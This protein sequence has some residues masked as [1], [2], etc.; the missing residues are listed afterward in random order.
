MQLDPNG[1]DVGL[2]FHLAIRDN[3]NHASQKQQSEKRKLGC[4]KKYEREIKPHAMG[5]GMT[6][7]IV[8]RLDPKMNPISPRKYVQGGISR[9]RYKGDGGKCFIT[10]KESAGWFQERTR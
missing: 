9:R 2:F 5:V 3:K 10:L 4:E 7:N 8:G 6:K 1:N